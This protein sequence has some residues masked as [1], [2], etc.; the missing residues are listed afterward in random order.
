MDKQPWLLRARHMSAQKC[1]KCVVKEGKGS[2][3]PTLLM[4]QKTEWLPG[5]GGSGQLLS[6][7]AEF[8]C[9]KIKSSGDGDG[10]TRI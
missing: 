3:F 2:G 10:C 1:A 6:T 9:E 8:R 4:G 5:A 7:G